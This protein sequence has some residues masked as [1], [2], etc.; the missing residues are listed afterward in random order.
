MADSHDGKIH[1]ARRGKATTAA[2]DLDALDVTDL[3][4]LAGWVV[5]P[6]WRAT[7]LL[8]LGL[9]PQLGAVVTPIIRRFDMAPHGRSVTTLFTT[10]R[11]Q[12]KWYLNETRSA[13]G[14]LN[15]WAVMRRAYFWYG[16]AE[17]ATR[18]S[19]F[20]EDL[21]ARVLE[22]LGG[23]GPEI[24]AMI[25]ASTADEI[26]GMRSGRG[27]CAHGFAGRPGP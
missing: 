4:I 1:I 7:L 16:P 11:K 2:R 9:A 8:E 17:C 6:S 3:E 18:S 22:G 21:T 27:A 12:E 25:E 5:G 10:I 23:D 20:A 15:A 26:M 19:R 13:Q 14:V 24:P